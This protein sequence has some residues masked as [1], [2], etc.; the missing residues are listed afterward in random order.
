MTRLPG[1]LRSARMTGSSIAAPGAAAWVT[2]FLNAAYY[3][4][5]D[6]VRDVSDLRLAHGIITTYWHGHRGRLGARHVLAL[7][8]AYGRR[9]I[10]QNGRLDREALLDG[11]G[12]LIGEWFS[13]AWYDDARRAHGIAFQTVAERDKFDPGSRLTHAALKSLTPPLEPP[14]KQHWATY[15]PVAL[16]DADATVAFLMEPARWPDMGC[17]NGRFTALRPCGLLGQTFEI[18]VVADPVPRAP[19][20]T[21]GY[22]TCTAIHTAEDEAA[23]E[24]AVDDLCSRYAE[25][26]GAESTELLPANARPLALVVLTTHEG[27]F[28]GRALSHLLIWGD[29]RGTWIRDVGAWD[30]LPMHLA[31]AYAAAGKAAQQ[32]FWGP[33]P[34]DRSML[35]QLAKVATA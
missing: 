34:P 28:L 11:A 35:A 25:G 33:E 7:N 15:D 14:S 23:L 21:R 32:Q 30:P 24:S 2:D 22:V 13:D 9:R 1:I 10:T 29:S 5:A 4:R 18:E 27:H 8:R 6:G 16:V 20:F 26:A 3:A 12:T 19:L 31:A 17:A